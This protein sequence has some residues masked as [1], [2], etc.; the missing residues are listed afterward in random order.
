MYNILH[1]QKQTIDMGHFT[2]MFF[3]FYSFLHGIFFRNPYMVLLTILTWFDFSYTGPKMKGLARKYGYDSPRPFCKTTNDAPICNGMP[4]GHT[5]SMAF[6]FSYVLCY[7]LLHKK[8]E[9]YFLVFLS[10]IGFIFM[11]IQR[12]ISNMHTPK[13]VL[14]G[15]IIGLLL[16][17]TILFPFH[18]IDK[19]INV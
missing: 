15:G 19:T 14:W 11:G 4:S 5:E 6:F 18:Y 8:Q 10:F 13:Q 12:V 16:G 2:P 17:P 9:N 7:S 3:I 1:L